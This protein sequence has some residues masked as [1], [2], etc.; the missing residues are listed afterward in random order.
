MLYF[1]PFLFS[2]LYRCRGGFL[3]TGSTTFARLGFWAAPAALW[4]CSINW[5]YAPFC[6]LAAYLGLLIP[7]APFQASASLKNAL[8]MSGIAMVRLALILAPLAYLYP[9]VPTV[10]PIMILS[11]IGYTVGWLFLNGI[12]APFGFATGGS[13]WG[14][15]ITGFAFGLAFTGVNLLVG[16]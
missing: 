9:L 5:R 1:Y 14:E 12:A 16:A 15:A 10:L 2:F 6:F 11:G 7:H 3:P 4:A 13:E 8:A